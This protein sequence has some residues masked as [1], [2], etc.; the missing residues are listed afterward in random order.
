MIKENIEYVEKKING[1]RIMGFK[2]KWWGRFLKNLNIVK[3]EY[4]GNV[5]VEGDKKIFFKK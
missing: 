2:C 3:E 5:K 4:G 1:F